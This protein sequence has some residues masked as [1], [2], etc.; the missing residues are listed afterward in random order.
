MY[1]YLIGE[2]LKKLTVDEII[3]YA[4]KKEYYITYNDAII[5]LSYAKKYYK[6]L[7]NGYPK[8]ILEEIKGKI[9]PITYKEAYKLYLEYKLKY[10]KKK[11]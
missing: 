3:T 5:L 8:E 4:K 2:Y 11:P 6:E 10:Q 9:N 7:L 1:D